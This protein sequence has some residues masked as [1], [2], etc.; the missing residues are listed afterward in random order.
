MRY[1]ITGNKGF[2]GKA[3]QKT[4]ES[5]LGFDKK[6]DASQNISNYYR[7]SSVVS[8]FEPDCIVHLAAVSG[9][10]DCIQDS[11][12]AFLTNV[13]GTYNIFESAVEN[14]VSRVVMASSGAVTE[15]LSPYHSHKRF[16]EDSAEV[17][18]RTHELSTCCLRFSNV[19]GAGSID[20]TSVV[21]SM[22][23]EAIISGTITVE[24][25][26]S[27][28]RDFIHIG[29]VVSAIKAAANCEYVGWLNVGGGNQYTIM[30]VAVAI[31]E[32]TGAVIRLTQSRKN[33]THKNIVDIGFTKDT[34]EW[35][36]SV[37]MFPELIKMYDYFKDEILT[38][39]V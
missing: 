8:N 37:E 9:I 29:D 22:F 16:L 30:S 11:E 17:Y 20:K 13:K 15:C 32:I 21:A 3:L 36:P 26:G 28:S 6:N 5:S 19:Y 14:K 12:K 7:I 2:I 4:V 35:E 31:R 27:Q 39:A 25:N 38:E 1:L 18:Y 34:L 10:K 33:D 23:K 24:G